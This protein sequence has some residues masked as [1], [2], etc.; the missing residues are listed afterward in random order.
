MKQI[1]EQIIQNL[2]T[3]KDKNLFHEQLELLKHNGL[4]YRKSQISFKINKLTKSFS[5]QIS[6]G[7]GSIVSFLFAIL[8]FTT[9][10]PYRIIE[11]LIMI[12]KLPFQLHEHK[13]IMKDLENHP[14]FKD[15]SNK[16]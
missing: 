12:I 1:T 13:K 9:I 8:W 2:S 5:N 14:K 6:R 4:E 10:F 15:L 11:I 3:C 7:I 16:F